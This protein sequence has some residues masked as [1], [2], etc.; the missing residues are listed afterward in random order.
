MKRLILFI[1][2]CSFLSCKKNNKAEENITDYY[3]VLKTAVITPAKII[4]G[5]S[6]TD[7]KNALGEG[8]CLASNYTF[9]FLSTGIYQVSSNGS[10]CDMVANNNDQKWSKDGNVITL[11]N[12]YAAIKQLTVSGN[13][14]LQTTSFT[15]NNVNYNII[16]TYSAIKK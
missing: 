9:N 6:T 13:V 16:Y 8:S 4:N 3:W 1:C 10:L 2:V 12:N 14:M 7:Y 5:K 11:L 15:E